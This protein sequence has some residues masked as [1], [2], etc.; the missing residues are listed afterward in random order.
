MAIQFAFTDRF[1]VAHPQAYALLES[2]SWTK[3]SGG[4]QMRYAVYASKAA[5]DAGGEP[6]LQADVFVPYDSSGMNSGIEQYLMAHDSVVAGGT[7]TQVA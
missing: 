3:D 2:G 6:V 4:F 1:K 5:H 7:P